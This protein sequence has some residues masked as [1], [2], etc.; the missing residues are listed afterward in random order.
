MNKILFK[1]IRNK[2]LLLTVAAASILGGCKKYLDQAP[3]T[4]VTSDLIF[5]NMTTTYQSLIA[6]YAQLAGDQGYG[7]VLSLYYPLDTDEIV[8]PASSTTDDRR[9]IAH[10]TLTPTNA[11]LEKPFD[12]LFRGIEYANICIDQ[13]PKMD[14]YN[15]GTDQQKKQL[16]RMVGEALTLRAQFYFEA[17]KNWGDLPAHFA[18]AA[19][20][21]V[22]NPF[23][24][25]TGRDTLYNH[26]LDDL[27]TA[28]DLVPW[29][30][31]I[32]AI[33]DPIDERITKGAVKGVRARIALFRGGYSLR[34]VAPSPALGVMQRPADYLTYYQIARDECNDIIT[35]G[36]HGLNPNFKSLWKDIICSHAVTDPQGELMFQVTAGALS[37]TG[38]FVS[39]SNSKIGFYNGPTLNGLGTKGA[40]IMPNYFYLFDSTDLRRDVTIAPYA[41]TVDGSGNLIKAGQ[42]LSSPSVYDGKYRRDWITNPVPS[43]SDG[44]GYFGLEWQL[45]RYSDVLL[46]FAEA[47]N[48]INNGPTTAAYE[49][50]NMVR[51]RGYGKAITTANAQVD[52][53][54]GLNK[55][56]FFKAIVRERA[57]ELGGEGIRKYDLIRWNLINTAFNENRT[58]LASMAAS[59]GLTAYSYMA[60]PPSYTM[61]VALPTSMYFKNNSV[62]DDVTLW[63]N[64]LYKAAPS[65]TPTGTTKVSW[66]GSTITTAVIPR[67]ASGFTPGKSE[68]L[69]FPQSR[70]DANFNLKQNPGY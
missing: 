18:P 13:I 8:G 66:L 16:R 38:Q 59:T 58:C 2:A 57:L 26:I 43:Y 69:P 41:V 53:P 39:T 4:S 35:N 48:E 21:A 55:T 14:L 65:S 11:E 67:F 12:Q 9:W 17:I 24:S 33:G 54:G 42:N 15:S 46:M 1:K 6:V 62:A 37:S 30:N 56:D 27:K 70:V 22:E 49:K 40:L 47:E 52:L 20:Q 36:Q 5:S 29:K 31:E 44:T 34:I 61:G 23:P 68:L 3:I 19:T 50:L 60:N 51:R 7:K 32:T 28:E 45:L 63:S 10:Y 25:K 64:S